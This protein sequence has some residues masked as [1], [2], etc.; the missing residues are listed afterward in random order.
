MSQV[1][2]LELSHAEHAVLLALADHADDDG[3]NVFPS[4]AYTAWKTNYK[5]RQVRRIVAALRERGILVLVR[6]ASRHRPN[7]Y[8]IDVAAAPKKPAFEEWKQARD[9]PQSREDKKSALHDARPDTVTALPAAS[10]DRM[11]ALGAD[12]GRS[13]ATARADIAM[14]TEPS[15]T[16]KATSSAK[17]E[18]VAPATEK[19]RTATGRWRRRVRRSL[20]WAASLARTGSSRKLPPQNEDARGVGRSA[21]VSRLLSEHALDAADARR[22]LRAERFLP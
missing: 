19:Q 2:G 7:E 18:D 8:R 17:A 13:S 12:L 16:T 20:R 22:R 21:R 1:W 9:V 6:E 11:S 10:T 4:I 14:S 3:S 15:G 5:E